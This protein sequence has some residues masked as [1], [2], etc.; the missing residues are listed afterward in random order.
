[1]DYLS[2]FG[3]QE[4]PF[5]LTPDPQFFFP[6]HTHQEALQTLL[7]SIRAGEGFIQITG[8][9]GTGKT[10]LLRTM[11]KELGSDVRTALILN[12]NLTP[13]DL[14]RVILDDFAIT[15][16]DQE[17]FSRPKDQ[18][19]RI[20]R[21]F[22]LLRAEEGCKVVIIVDEAQNL[23]LETIEELR[24]LSNL[25]TD[26]EKLLQIFLVGQREL[27]KKIE[28][29]SLRQLSQR[30]TI[31]YCLMPFNPQETATYIQ[32][33]LQV[34]APSN[35]AL[36]PPEIIGLIHKFSQG[37]PRLIN[38]ICERTLMAAY[39]DG[40]TLIS[41]RHYDN[42]LL[43]IRGEQAASHPQRKKTGSFSAQKL[44]LA[45]LL[46]VFAAGLFLIYQPPGQYLGLSQKWLTSLLPSSGKTRS[47]CNAATTRSNKVQ[48]AEQMQPALEKTDSEPAA[49]PP[50]PALKIAPNQAAKTPLLKPEAMK[51][52][53]AAVVEF[54]PGTA[55]LVACEGARIA[56]LWHQ[57]DNPVTPAISGQLPLPEGLRAGLMIAGLNHGH[58][59]LFS[60][61]NFLY[62]EQTLLPENWHQFFQNRTEKVIPLLLLPAKT[63]L[64]YPPEKTEKDQ[65]TLVRKRTGDLIKQT[66]NAWAA[67]W[68][69]QDLETLMAFYAPVLTIYEPGQLKP[70]SLEKEKLKEIKARLFQKTASLELTLSEPLCLIDPL[71]ENL[72]LAFFSQDYQ[73]NQYRDK[74]YK[75]LFLSRIKPDEKTEKWLISGKFFVPVED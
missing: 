38:I 56:D 19:I 73:S 33:R 14:L 57:E 9:P 15:S 28:D 24:L 31:R 41:R 12:P 40:Q 45:V 18:L 63:A 75:T 55:L 66:V 1:M 53:P 61:L 30:I 58:P 59:F 47:T 54:P 39:I 50:V 74:G 69:D 65:I 22:L 20:F 67:A 43:S 5:R 21:D 32:H 49:Q 25:E 13:Q 71:N 70:L 62:G 29:I 16:N 48:A 34:A 4:A 68:R 27:E 26:K 52:L 44:L 60:P 17:I 35:P 72:A 3:F 23:P 46:L 11:L 8:D 2:F 6:S 37:T 10:L 42:A 7:Y 64:G 36:F 51:N